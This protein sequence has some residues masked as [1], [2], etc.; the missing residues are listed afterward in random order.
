MQSTVKMEVTSYDIAN[1][2]SLVKDEIMTHLFDRS[3]WF[4]G[5]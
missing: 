5:G 4:G 2:E 3:A 1:W